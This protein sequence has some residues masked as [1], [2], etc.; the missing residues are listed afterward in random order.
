MPLIETL[1]LHVEYAIY[2]LIQNSL[3]E[4]VGVKLTGL[5]SS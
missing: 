5:E 3:K 4:I 1:E 2:G